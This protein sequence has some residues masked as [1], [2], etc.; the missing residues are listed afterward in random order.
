MQNSGPRPEDLVTI[1]AEEV[2]R[3][4]LARVVLLPD[5]QVADQVT[6]L[7]AA[8][9]LPAVQVLEGR[10]T[11]HL[12]ALPLVQAQARLLADLA[13]TRAALVLPAPPALAQHRED[14]AT[15]RDLQVQVALLPGRFRF[16]LRRAAHAIT[17]LQL[18]ELV[19]SHHATSR[20]QVP[21]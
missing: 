9:V 4:A 11:I 16:R 8:L 14:L 19:I 20:F 7:H 6:I 17:H 5:P 3:R 15:I 2:L 21:F 12:E 18:S 13:T 1:Q 10:A